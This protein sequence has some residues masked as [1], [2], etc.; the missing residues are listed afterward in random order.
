MRILHISPSFYPAVRY[1][2]P[3]YISDSLTRSLVELG[4]DVH[5]YAT[6]IDGPGESDV[7]VDTPIDRDGVKI[8]YFRP[9]WGRRFY[10]SCALEEAVRSSIATFDV[11][12]L[13]AV[14][15][16]STVVGARHAR[17]SEIPY[18]L[19]PYGMLI[20]DLIRHRSR[21]IKQ[22][23][24][25]LFDRA[26]L[27]GAAAVHVA[28]E[29]EAAEFRKLGLKARRL[30]E[31]P[32]SVDLPDLFGAPQGNSG[33]AR[34]EESRQTVLFLSRV[35]WKKGLDRLIRAIALIPD[36]DL[37]I[38]GN[39]EENYTEELLRLAQL[40]GV[41]DRTHFVGAVRGNRKWELLRAA[42]VLALPS[43]S[44]NF[45]VVV[46]EAMAVGCPV[47]VTPEVGM[48]KSVAELGTGLVVEGEPEQF[49]C[50]LRRILMDQALRQSMSIAG[51]RAVN[52][53]FTA[54]AVARRMADLY[55]ECC[56]R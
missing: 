13:H 42:T 27:A 47:V 53:R 30:V 25:R 15:S 3:V 51:P 8:T 28:S 24:I 9:D 43:Y 10:R 1:G 2:G 6:N 26:N 44:E 29:I 49:A 40:V 35:N 45:A 11:V 33:G 22:S 38:A 41:A 55:R 54:V 46:L 12:H 18:V 50:G 4:H 16:W 32:Y 21:W 34:G 39:D 14:F 52:E 19:T 31:I 36:V 7:P 17:R 23:W 20:E 48:A 56:Q 5:V 37:V